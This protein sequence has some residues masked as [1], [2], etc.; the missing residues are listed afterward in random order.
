MWLSKDLRDG[1]STVS[2]KFS[3][4]LDTLTTNNQ[5]NSNMP[6]CLTIDA[7]ALE[8]SVSPMVNNSN[9]PSGLSLHEILEIARLA[10]ANRNVSV[11]SFLMQTSSL[12]IYYSLPLSLSFRLS[13]Y[14]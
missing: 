2:Q 13:A 4:L 11:K 7:G 10:G 6:V 1:Q 12:I 9:S 14:S 3:T 8:A 5:S